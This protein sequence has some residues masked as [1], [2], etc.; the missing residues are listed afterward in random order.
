M[1]NKLQKEEAET[2]KTPECKRKPV[3]TATIPVNAVLVFLAVSI[4]S[5][6]I[7]DVLP[8]KHRFWNWEQKN[9]TT[10]AKFCTE[11]KTYAI[12]GK[13]KNEDHLIHVVNVLER[14]GYS[15]VNLENNWNLLWAH[16]YPFIKMPQRMKSLQK[17]QVVNHF[18]GCGFITNKVDLSTSELP[19]L[20]RAFRLPSQKEDFLAYSRANPSALFVEKHNEHRHIVIRPPE[21]ID[22][23]SNNSFV[24]EYIQNPFLVDG[25]KFDIGVYVVI[26]SVN[27]LRIYMYSGDILFRYCPVQ[28]HPFDAANIDKYVVG[29][30]YLPTWQ[31]PSLKKYFSQFGGSMRSAFDAYVRDQQM[32]PSTI[33]QQVED[34]I[35]RTILSKER[36]IVN[37]LRSYKTQNF[38]DL[39]RFDLIVD[40]NLKV[41]LME[42]NMSPN[43]SSAHFKPNSILY[44]QI[45]YNVLNLV[46]IGSPIKQTE[47]CRSNAPNEMITTEQNLSTNLNECAARGCDRSCN[48]PGCD[49]CLPCLRGSEYEMLY[50]AH[51]E[52]LHRGSMKRLFPPPF[53]RPDTIVIENEVQNMTKLNSWMTR[54]F[55]HKCLYDNSWCH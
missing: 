17:H 42:A 8:I 19:F 11:D 27:P 55:Y 24:Q 9:V 26:T 43:L 51:R 14:L 41:F 31:V 38:F 34:I 32:D 45:L 22:L 18:P 52:H 3:S 20:P 23:N 16:D 13:S 39:M 21:E 46:G 54:W 7:I 25:H 6:V 35:R 29:D 10:R 49:L 44:E 30:D 36:D 50:R 28:Y 37:I 47:D 15:R 48:K 5:S 33:W 40:Q 53:L 2:G 1:E 12:Y 4:I